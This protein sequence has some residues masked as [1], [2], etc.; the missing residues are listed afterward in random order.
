MGKLRP[1][2]MKLLAQLVTELGLQPG[3][4]ELSVHLGHHSPIRVDG[5]TT[6]ECPLG[7]LG[8][9]WGRQCSHKP[10]WC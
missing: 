4:S 10:S 9:Q 2:D 8:V 7:G 6:V 1:G 5:K 3:S